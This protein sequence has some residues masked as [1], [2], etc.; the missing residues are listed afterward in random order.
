MLQYC[1]NCGSYFCKFIMCV[2]EHKSQRESIIQCESQNMFK[3]I[4]TSDCKQNIIIKQRFIYINKKK[5]E[6]K[7]GQ[8][9]K[10][11]SRS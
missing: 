5:K 9:N 8:N 7:G 4:K 1:N 3:G 6:R 11:I 10:Q 2:K